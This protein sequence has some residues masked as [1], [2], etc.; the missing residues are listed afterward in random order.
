MH[1]IDFI[2]RTLRGIFLYLLFGYTILQIREVYFPSL[3][4]KAIHECL[5]N[6][7]ELHCGNPSQDWFRIPTDP[8]TQI[9]L[10][11]KEK[12]D[13]LKRYAKLDE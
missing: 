10:N 7:D 1:I 8:A 6:A 9:T 5:L 4:L 11:A 2:P 3:T 12:D 13:I